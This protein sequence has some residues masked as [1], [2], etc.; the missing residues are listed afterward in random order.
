VPR[1]YFKLPRLKKE[2]ATD[3]PHNPEASGRTEQISKKLVVAGSRAKPFFGV[4][5]GT[6][7]KDA[8]LVSFLDPY[9]TRFSKLNRKLAQAI[10]QVV[11]V[12]TFAVRSDEA[13][14]I[15][16][17]GACSKKGMLAKIYH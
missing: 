6:A 16:R 8:S 13:T 12:G 7:S 1:A 14:P 9:T 15:R 3:S 5:P 11:R 10:S 2:I 4:T 17:E